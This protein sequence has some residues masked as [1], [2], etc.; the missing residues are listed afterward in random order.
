MYWLPEWPDEVDE[1]PTVEAREDPD[2]L[3]NLTLPDLRLDSRSD[4]MNFVVPAGAE[5][6]SL[7]VDSVAVIETAAHVL[8]GFEMQE[9]RSQWDVYCADLTR[10]KRGGRCSGAQGNLE[11]LFNESGESCGCG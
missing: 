5:I 11:L 1:P 7:F 3:S 4:M 8:P 10:R 2:P 9:Q 6:A